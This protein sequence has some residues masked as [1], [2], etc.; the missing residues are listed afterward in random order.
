MDIK[1]AFRKIKN[2]VYNYDDAERRIRE[3]T[4]NNEE[5]KPTN[6]Q[7]NEI[8]NDTRNA[9]L[10]QTMFRMLWKRLHDYQHMQHVLK[11]LM[12]TEYCILHGHQRFRNDM[13]NERRIEIVRRLR[14]YKFLHDNK[15]IA[16]EVRVRAK[17]VVDLLENKEKM[18]E[19]LEKAKHTR[20]A[21]SGPAPG[22]KE[23]PETVEGEP[24]P[25][26]QPAVKP[27]PPV[28]AAPVVEE[29][30]VDDDPFG[31]F[32]DFGFCSCKASPARRRCTECADCWSTS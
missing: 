6:E 5:Q 19:A 25:P 7:L 16:G 29:K 18:A 14:G 15:E 1:G 9:E 20:Q 11:G 4:N 28:Q 22:A 23:H 24:D 8:A 32:D 26:A 12:V 2:N 13:T 10:Y 27:E 31:A 3:A 30:V 21:I 17:R